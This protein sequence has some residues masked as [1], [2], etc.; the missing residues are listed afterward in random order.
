MPMACERRV[1]CNTIRMKETWRW[2]GPQDL[3]SLDQIKQAGATGIVRPASHLPRETW[4][5]D[6]VLKRKSGN[7]AA[8]R[9]VV[10]ES[11]PVPIPSSSAQ[12][13][14]HTSRLKDSLAAI[15]KEAY[16]S[17]AITSCR[18]STGRGRIE[19]APARTGYALRFDAVDSRLRLFLLERTGAE[20][21]YTPERL[22]AARA[23][24]TRV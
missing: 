5:L 22:A 10:V 17:F 3:I 21:D 14:C 8:A 20:L 23:A 4:P 6:E 16:R 12:G 2:F 9:L 15:A 7:R 18:S 24:S 13:R 19:V 1:K 11:I